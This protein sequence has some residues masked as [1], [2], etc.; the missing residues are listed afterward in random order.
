VKGVSSACGIVLAVAALLVACNSSIEPPDVI[1]ASPP[2]TCGNGVVEPGE[3]CD[4]GNSQNSD[5]CLTT[6]Q[7]PV[8]WVASDVHVHSTGCNRYTSPEDLVQR[9]KA[10]GLQVA[11][12]LVWGEGFYDDEPFFTG[13][14][15]PAS[16]PG[17]ILH[18]DMEV[19]HFAAAR[20][21]H[22]LLLGLDSLHFSDDVISTPSSGVP[23]VEWARRQPRA[24]VGMAH[25]HYW[26]DDGSFPVPPGGCCVPW[27]VVVHAAR[28][29]L[30]FLSMERVPPGQGAVDAGTFRLWKAMQNSGFRVAITGSSDWGCLT[31]VFGGDTPRT[32]VIVD[33]PLTY[34]AWLKAIKAGRTA[35]ASGGGSRLNLR[36]ETR[37]LG[38]ELSLPAPGDVAVTLESEGPSPTDV[39]LLVNGEVVSRVPVAGGFQV[40]QFRVPILK[41][42]WI[43]ARSPQVLTSPI[44][45]VVGGQPIR[46][47]AGDV[48]YLWRAV[49]YL[50]GLVTSGRLRITDG[51]DEALRA[52][53]DA[54]TELQRRFTESGGQFC[55]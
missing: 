50:E 26:P 52:Y 46:A 40:A 7:Q 10:Q 9:L 5:G 38:D 47:S 4:D 32:Q 21:G 3:P 22:L 1:S 11:A 13:R 28:S 20:T 44:Y 16:E 55:R 6:C 14:D 17:F 37:L 27:E 19:S 24:V 29:R 12:A 25:G 53:A 48:C 30:D 31:Q 18:Y 2:P 34:E 51:R 8:K 54:V 15:H 39:E 36:V 49:K 23:V 42:S 43:A 41:S 35:A 33:G 45:V